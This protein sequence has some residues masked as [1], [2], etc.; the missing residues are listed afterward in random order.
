MKTPIIIANW[1]L[2]HK[3]VKQA[4]SLAEKIKKKLESSNISTVK[5]SIAPSIIHLLGVK[6]VLS[7]GLISLASQT[8]S[9][10]DLGAHTGEIAA[11]Q[12]KSAGV[13]FVI[14]GHSE[15]RSGGV[16]DDDVK[17][18]TSSALSAGLTPVI[19]VGESQRDKS[20]KFFTEIENQLKT[21]LLNLPPDR[22]KKI[23][24][25]YEPVWA[26]GTG[27]V[28]TVEIVRE[29]KIFIEG[30]IA[31]L[32][33]RDLASRVQIIYGGSVKPDN[34]VSLWKESDM[35]GFLVGGASLKASDFTKIVLAV[36]Q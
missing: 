22:I 16:N 33:N 1:K 31:R 20:G 13:K 29:M 17:I 26:I 11:V 27:K 36:A 19:C 9:T 24:I 14:I 30:V 4:V 3:T 18:K 8:V 7:G 5:V 15:R 10:C 23:I 2:H 32:Y 34:V 28:A 35:S 25:A 6:D 12:L 21:A